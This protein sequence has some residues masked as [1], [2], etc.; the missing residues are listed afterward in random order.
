MRTE[1]SPDRL[2]NPH[3]AAVERNLRACV[4]CG[5]C[6]ATCPTYVLTGDERDG[7]R[8]RIVMMQ[9][10][11]ESDD[12]PTAETVRHIDRCL[13]C[14]GCR[15]ACPSSV[16]YARLVDHSRAH[17]HETYRRPWNE[18]WLRA[19]IAFVMARPAL[20]RFGLRLAHFFAPIATL[21]PGSLGAMARKAVAMPPPTDNTPL[22]KS[23]A[24]R[25]VALMPGCVQQALAP[26]IDRAAQS[27][28]ARRGIALNTLEGAGCCGALAHHLGRRDEAKA[29]AKQ[30]ITAFEKSDAGLVL[31]TATGCAAH[32]ADYTELFCDEPDWQPRAQ[33]FVA[34]VRDF[35]DLA[36]PKSAFAPERL[37]VAHHIPCSLQHGLKRGNS[38][39]AALKAAGFEVADIPEGHLCCGSAGSYSLLQPE[40]AA[41]LRRRKLDNIAVLEADVVASANIGCLSHLSGPDAPPVIHPAELIDWA[42]GGPRP[43]AL[44]PKSPVAADRGSR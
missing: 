18:K 8:G 19:S 11:L 44:G 34:K 32:L 26:S 36:Q 40:M 15:T 17:I 2:A 22:P 12:A 7:P 43:A 10:M 25:R 29:W 16:D 20:V 6:T 37:R 28:L 5:I 39:E 4:H 1:L 33:A 31:I 35:S 14:L 21:L 23:T 13:S 41:A 38:G 24:A 42:E 30:A 27:V 9:R 3:I